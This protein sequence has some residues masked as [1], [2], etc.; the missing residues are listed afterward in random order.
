MNDEQTITALR[1]ATEHATRDHHLD[2]GAAATAW[3]T[4]WPAAHR[5]SRG[6][7]VAA[8]AASVAVTAGGAAAVATWAH[9]RD[10]PPA[11]GGGS[12]CSLTSDP[13][14]TWARTGFSP[15]AYRT[16]HVMGKDGRIVA[17]P[18]IRLRVHQPPDAGNKVLWV[19]KAGYGPLRIEATLEGTSRT[20]VRTL[21]DGP[22]PSYV[23]MPAPGCWR[24]DL[25]WAGRHDSLG[26]RYYP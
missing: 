22:G 13:L 14:P 1:Q 15:G 9:H 24:M 11:G 19:S 20:V 10:S 21:P 18:F 8:V 3:D 12:A 17:I 4:A 6:R 2:P 25:S 7:L 5:R 26:L 23:D 16:P